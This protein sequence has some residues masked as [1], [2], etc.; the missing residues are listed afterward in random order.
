MNLE[1]ARQRIDKVNEDL[2]IT[3]ARIQLQEALVHELERDG[4]G[5]CCSKRGRTTNIEMSGTAYDTSE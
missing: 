1:E 3:D 2:A 5:F 4:H